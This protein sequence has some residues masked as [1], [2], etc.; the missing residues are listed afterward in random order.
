[1]SNSQLAAIFLFFL[2]VTLPIAL[3]FMPSPDAMAA[4]AFGYLLAGGGI[5][6]VLLAN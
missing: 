3:F 6:A 4:V 5:A 2:A 1:M